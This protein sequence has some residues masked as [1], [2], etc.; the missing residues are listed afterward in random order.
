MSIGIDNEQLHFFR[1]NRKIEFEDF[2]SKRDIQALEA[3]FKKIVDESR[4]DP[5]YPLKLGFDIHRKVSSLKPLITRK[6]YAHLAAQ[7]ME[8]E[9]LR[10]GFSQYLSRACYDNHFAYQHSKSCIRHF[11]CGICLCLEAS[12]EPENPYFP[13]EAGSAV[14]FDIDDDFYIKFP[15]TKGTFIF[16]FYAN[17]KAFFAHSSSDPMNAHFRSLG[18]EH[19]DHLKES[20]N[21]SYSWMVL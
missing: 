21:P 9:R 19:G 14:F 6:K 10:F 15:K 8:K 16:I 4:L 11:Q 2:L 7:L 20:L 3:G 5:P 18:Y 1:K 13:K 17:P 12:D